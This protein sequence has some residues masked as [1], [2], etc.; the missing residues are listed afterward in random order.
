MIAQ[1]II[2]LSSS[3]CCASAAARRACA[4]GT[5]METKSKQYTF[6]PRCV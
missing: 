5:A 6:I 3:Y 2:P 4:G 1:A